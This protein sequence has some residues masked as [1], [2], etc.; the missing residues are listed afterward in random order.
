[1]NPRRSF[2]SRLAFAY[3]AMVTATVLIV[4]V[5]GRLIVGHQLIRGL[6]L[7]NVAEF[8]EIR[9]HIAAPAT[10]LLDEPTLAVLRE[11]TT[12]DSP[13]YFFQVCAPNGR[14]LFRSA[15]LGHSALPPPSGQARHY[16]VEVRPEPGPLRVGEFALGA[17]WIEI[18][19]SREAAD[20]LLS[21]LTMTL[22]TLSAVVAL[23]SL[24]VGYWF[25]RLA[26][27]PVR[28][29]E[30]TA[31][32]IGAANLRERIPVPASRDELAELARLLNHMFDRI[33]TAFTQV[34]RFTAEASHE[35]KT[36][37]ALARLHAEKLART[38]LTP[39][40]SEEAQALLEELARLQKIIEDLLLLSRADAGEMPLNRRDHAI[41]AF[42]AEFAE[43]ARTL[44]EDR[45][46]RF[47]L[48]SN[49]RGVAPFD[50]AWLRRVLLNLLSNALKFSPP[51]GML[52]FASTIV[53]GRWQMSL[54]D[55]GPGVPP[56]ELERIFERFVQLG[57]RNA[58]AENGAGLGLA[59][60]RSITELH[61]GRLWAENRPD[62]S[63]LKVILEIPAA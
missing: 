50:P 14:V 22:L 28:A 24:A 32:A 55:E 54:A 4:L 53:N 2:T 43:D 20:T 57:G 39:A 35:L 34:R 30:R 27:Q 10:P 6:D 56:P 18:A 12:I 11:H 62:R 41:E 3:A 16:S 37:L 47:A 33:E 23:G 51:G 15:N 42:V 7:L 8:E 59:I 19:G 9:T 61:R 44:A 26:L 31:A 17:V 1:M 29:I 38:E 25:S 60:A 48:A 21:R 63:G 49:D 45:G 40:Q 5:A 36:P 13:M 52:T 46:M 58:E